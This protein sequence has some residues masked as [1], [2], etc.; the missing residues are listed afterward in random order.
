MNIWRN[1]FEANDVFIFI[2]KKFYDLLLH[3][4]IKIEDLD[5]IIFDECHHA[6]Q[7][8]LYNILMRDFFF[9]YIFN[10]KYP[11]SKLKEGISRPKILGL[12][13]SPIK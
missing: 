4:Y 10:V 7:E 5:L 2:A 9:Q 6:D 3:G 11:Y 13:A 12:T 8:H 1:E